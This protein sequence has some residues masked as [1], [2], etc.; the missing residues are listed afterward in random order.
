MGRI[1]LGH[2]G[3]RF[4]L[5]PWLRGL[6]PSICRYVS[7]FLEK[8]GEHEACWRL[9]GGLISMQQAALGLEKAGACGKPLLGRLAAGMLRPGGKVGTTI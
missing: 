6:C 8:S 9:L 5:F 1:L 7:F 3:N 2:L 4:S